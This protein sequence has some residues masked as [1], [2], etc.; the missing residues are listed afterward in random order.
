MDKYDI[1]NDIALR[2]EGDIYVGV[3]GPVRSGKSTFI[4]KFME[5]FVL[6]NIMDKYKRERVVDELPQSGDG[7]TIMTTQP[8]FVPGESVKVSLKENVEVNVRLIDCVGYVVDGAIGVKEG[9]KERYVKTP[10][11]DSDMPFEKAAETG[12]QKV[13]NEH[14]TIGIIVT[15]DGSITDLPR[16]SYINAEER[17]IRELKALN[18]PF[19]VILNSKTPKDSETQ[20][21]QK[22]L[23]EKYQVPVLAID[24]LKI[25]AEE[26]ADIF[27]GILLEFPLRR[28]DIDLSDWLS[29]LPQSNNTIREIVSQVSEVCQNMIKMKDYEAVNKLFGE[30]AKLNP[31]QELQVKLGEGKIRFKISAKPELFYSVLSEIADED[32]KSDF[33]I[34][35]YVTNLSSSKKEYDRIKTA[36]K[37]VEEKGYG[38][39]TPGLEEMML[40]VPEIVKSGG[41]FGVRLKASAPSLHIM[42][43]D[44][45]TEVSPIVGTEQQSEELVKYLLSEFENDPKGIW[46][47]NMFGKSLHNL[48]KEGLNN[49]LHAMPSDAQ[50]KMRR[51]IGRIVNEGKGG[52][53]C[54]LL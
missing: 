52:I 43:V 9:N 35:A 40:E 45:N 30:S 46:E 49:K 54:I 33:K 44:I 6:P 21:L 16:G 20:K 31:P 25:S 29:A 32:I 15:T 53:I 10:W 26:I 3:V 17:V 37:E 13:I 50:A 27:E 47:T 11:S 7:K 38:V 5:N 2:T 4:T 22:S 12:T 8:K 41:K 48:V 1:Y 42:K 24:V 39:V 18:K 34:M 51:T 36:L 23:Q 28:I 14:S 19:V